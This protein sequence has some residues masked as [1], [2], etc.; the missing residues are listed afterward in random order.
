VTVSQVRWVLPGRHLDAGDG[1]VL[2]VPGLIAQLDEPGT[3][4][5]AGEPVPVMATVQM[6]CGCPL[7]PGGLWDSDG[8][9]VTLHAR[10]EAG[11]PVTTRLDHAGEASRFG[12]SFTPARAGTWE[13]ELRA[14]QPATGNAGVATRR[15][16]VR[17]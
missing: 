3:E 15:I 5:R 17:E 12:G 16:E 9:E 11:E 7:T 13:L 8:F 10:P 2:E 4:P 1:W 6:M 14:W